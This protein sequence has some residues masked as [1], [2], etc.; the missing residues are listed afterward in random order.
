MLGRSVLMMASNAG[1]ILL[2][3]AY[4]HDFLDRVIAADAAAGNTL[5]LELAVTDAISTCLQA[6]V[7]DGILGV[8]GGVLAQAASLIKASCF[9]MGARTLSGALVPLAADMPAPTS[10]NFV[11]GDYNRRT[12][13]KG[14]A[15]TKYLLSGTNSNSSPVTNNHCSVFATELP[16]ANFQTMIGGGTNYRLLRGNA[17]YN[18][19]NHT[20][21]LTT[22]SATVGFF[23]TTR[24][25]TSSYT[26]RGGGVNVAG[27]AVSS[28]DTSQVAVFGLPT[29][30]R[31]D[32]RLSFYSIG[33]ALDLAILDARISALSN[34]I[35]AAI[36]A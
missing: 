24:S 21:A 32:A 5:G 15:S 31:T 8:S 22:T 2:Y 26:A 34:A 19:T 29:V 1:R 36:P 9:M 27:G 18:A 28:E 30:S 23:G 13:A 7:G 33:Q 4:V 35:Q 14:N 25:S 12:G 17:Q 16:S 6:L 11:A 10:F 20:I 3:P